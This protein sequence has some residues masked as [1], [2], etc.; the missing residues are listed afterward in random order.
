MKKANNIVQ[1]SLT[2]I[3]FSFFI[4]WIILNNLMKEKYDLWNILGLI[5]LYL[6]YISIKRFPYK[7]TFL[8]LL[9]VGSIIEIVIV[10]LQFSGIMESNHSLFKITGTFRNPGPLGGFM[11]I[12]CIATSG[13][14]IK[15]KQKK[16]F[17]ICL[18]SLIVCNVIVLILSDS[19]SGWLAALLGIL[20]LFRKKIQ[21]N[22]WSRT[23]KLGSIF[24]ILLFCINLYFYK[25]DSA[26]GRI[27]IWKVT[28]NMIADQPLSGHGNNSFSEKYMYYQAR[29]F[30]SHPHS[31]YMQYAN[32]V[33][34][35]FN[36]ILHL[37]VEN[38]FIAI[39]LALWILYS[40]SYHTKSEEDKTLIALLLVICTFSMASYPFYI[41]EFKILFIFL[42]ASTKSKT[43]YSFKI[44][45][46]NE[47]IFCVITFSLGIGLFGFKYYKKLELESYLQM[48]Y[49]APSYDT[50]LN[51]N[52]YIKTN[53][54]NL[55]NAPELFYL[56][57]IYSCQYHNISDNKIILEEAIQKVP[58]P[59]LL[60]NFAVL[61]KQEQNYNRAI[62]IF[63]IAQYMIPYY[64]RPRYE[65]FLLYR[66]IGKQEEVIRVIKDAMALPIKTYNTD[67]LKM[68]GEMNRYYKEFNH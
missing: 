63:R 58:S 32:S 29:F 64:I 24:I 15:Y 1:L 56:Y 46:F 23:A 62:Q 68:R 38:G 55:L 65:L 16:C 7:H 49:Q 18:L 5:A 37:W 20:Y 39:V 52:K 35:P 10:L 50:G 6:I 2:N 31:K 47:K 4:F 42:L 41:D 67:A 57:A 21:W 45:G 11:A 12:T 53:Y 54:Y 13:L 22:V 28:C 59:I 25:K 36:E 17:S 30:E 3:A 43:Y 60:C 26:D 33:S 44:S 66:D 34:Y 48:I 14:W 8:W 51:S 27:L 9:A 19:R 40:L 61:C